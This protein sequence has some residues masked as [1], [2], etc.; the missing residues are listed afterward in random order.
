MCLICPGVKKSPQ[1]HASH[2]LVK[3]LGPL[4]SECLKQLAFDEG[5]RNFRPA[6]RQKEALVN[7]TRQPEGM[8]YGALNRSTIIGYVTFHRPNKYSRWNKHPRILELGTIEVTPK[9]RKFKIARQLLELAFGNPVLEDYV[10]ITIEF[11]WHWDLEQSRLNVW[12]YQKM[13][14]R[15][16]GSVNMQRIPTDDPSILEHPANV[17]MVKF[18]KHV[19]PADL[20]LFSALQFE[21]IKEPSYFPATGNQT[22]VINLKDRT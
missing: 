17:L 16:L 4:S 22:S 7:I 6:D 14:T 2:G 8:V 1:A 18:G 13:L 12:Q 11:C 20:K 19:S 15:L 21:K 10:I 9:W 5:L 3:I